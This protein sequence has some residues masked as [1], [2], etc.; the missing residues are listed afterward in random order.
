MMNYT[1]VYSAVIKGARYLVLYQSIVERRDQITRLRQTMSK[2]KA[3]EKAEGLFRIVRRKV[4]RFMTRMPGEEEADPTP[5]NWIINTRMY[6]MKIRYTTPGKETID[7]QGDQIK[8]GQV[9]LRMG[10]ISDILHNV[11][12]EARQTLAVLTMTDAAATNP[13]PASIREAA[14]EAVREG[15]NETAP[16]QKDQEPSIQEV[17]PRIPWSRIDDRHGESGLEHSFLR[18]EAN[19]W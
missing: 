7:W 4:R 2:K 17:L 14:R 13:R 19:R 10:Q 3:K 11:L 1:T 16:D 15:D 12:K 6:G 9:R 5:M 8:C 18:N